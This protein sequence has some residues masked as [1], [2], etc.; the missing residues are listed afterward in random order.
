MPY[1]VGG[2]S[3]IED[4]IFDRLWDVATPRGADSTEPPNV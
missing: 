2:L 3:T 1:S 4:K